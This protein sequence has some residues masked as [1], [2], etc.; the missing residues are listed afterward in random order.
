MWFSHNCLIISSQS[1]A[2]SNPFFFNL[3]WLFSVYGHKCAY[4][5][6]LLKD[7]I[8]EYSGD[9]DLLSIYA[10]KFIQGIF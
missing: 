10:W 9:N 4:V 7:L 1:S 5:V 3:L 6:N 8:L 2:V